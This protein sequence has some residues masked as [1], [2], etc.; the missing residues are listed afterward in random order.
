MVGAISYKHQILKK[1]VFKILLWIIKFTLIISGNGKHSQKNK[2]KQNKKK[3]TKTKKKKNVIFATETK[4]DKKNH[5]RKQ[6]RV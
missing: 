1:S 6:R 5:V 3:K 2:T 4:V